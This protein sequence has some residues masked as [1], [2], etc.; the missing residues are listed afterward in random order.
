M[1]RLLAVLKGKNE[2]ELIGRGENAEQLHET[3]TLKIKL[4]CK[5]KCQAQSQML[6]H[7]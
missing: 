2:G 4:K 1:S 5:L 6:L 7:H 3:L